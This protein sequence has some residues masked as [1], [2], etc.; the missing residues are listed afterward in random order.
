LLT[1]LGF[2]VVE[3]KSLSRVRVDEIVQH[4]DPNRRRTVG[5]LAE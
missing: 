4:W 3:S 2:I 1:L 5:P